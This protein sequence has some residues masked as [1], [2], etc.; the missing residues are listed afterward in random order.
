MTRRIILA[1]LVIAASIASDQATE[2]LAKRYLIL[3]E[4]ISLASDTMQEREPGLYL[5]PTI[6]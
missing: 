2:L 5:L 6:K 3:G 1:L 4:T